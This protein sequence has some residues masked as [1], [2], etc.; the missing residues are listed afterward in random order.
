MAY[1]ETPSDLGRMIRTQRNRA[2]WDQAQLA[3]A[4]GVSRQWIIDMEKGKPR[5]ELHL[6]LRTLDALGLRL[7]LGSVGVSAVGV[8]VPGETYV[9][10]ID[11]DQVIKKLSSKAGRFM[12]IS[13]PQGKP[14]A[15]SRPGEKQG[16]TLIRGAPKKQSA[17]NGLKEKANRNREKVGTLMQLPAV[18]KRPASKKVIPKRKLK[19]DGRNIV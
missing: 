10:K 17:D 7:S 3:S 18:E 9:P 5:A 2:G 4:V 13:S 16:N 14:V 1:I 8:S 15:A 6:V 19:S 11:I 12:T